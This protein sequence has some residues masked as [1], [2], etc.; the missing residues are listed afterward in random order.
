MS[1]YRALSRTIIK[2]Y[3]ETRAVVPWYQQEQQLTAFEQWFKERLYPFWFKFVKGPYER[4][5][6]E[7][8]VAEL[9]GYGLMFDDMHNTHEPIMERAME[10]L[11]HDLSV[12][13]Y[14]RVMRAFEMNTK[15]THLPVEEQNYDPMIPY[16]APFMEEAKFQMQEEQELLRFH[17]WDRRLYSGPTTGLGENTPYSAFSV[18]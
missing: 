11:P 2:N 5:Q 6:Y 15:K 9:R 1:F 18:W 3:V 10:L 13:R 7:H 17:P 12:G 8:V 14:R 16:L 4:Y